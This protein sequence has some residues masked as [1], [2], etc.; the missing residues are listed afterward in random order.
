L[1]DIAV[2]R[3]MAAAGATVEMI[4]AAVEAAQKTHED[5]LA[6][7][8]ASDVARQQKRRGKSCDAA[9]SHV[10]SRDPLTSSDDVCDSRDPET[11]S[12]PSP[13]LKKGLPHTPSKEITPPAPTPPAPRAS[14]SAEKRGLPADFEL[15]ESDNRF[16]LDRGWTPD[17]LSS[18]L[19]RFV[20]HARANNRK[21]ADWHAAWRNWV[22]SPFQAPKANG[23]SHNGPPSKP[24]VSDVLAR[25]CDET[26]PDFDGLFPQIGRQ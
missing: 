18:E 15:S 3:A 2:L 4:L 11:P 22:T 1:I 23:A 21:Q 5:A 14:R 24:S 25:L 16:A 20:D 17:K 9:P 12:P 8:R 10:T 7:R 19:A 13:P 26:S 6:K